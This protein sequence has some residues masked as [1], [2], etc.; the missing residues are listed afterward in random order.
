VQV[1]E[2]STRKFVP[3][4]HAAMI[5]WMFRQRYKNNSFLKEFTAASFSSVSGE[6]W[7]KLIKES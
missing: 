7:R 5:L 6:V 1:A 2:N 4:H 3:L